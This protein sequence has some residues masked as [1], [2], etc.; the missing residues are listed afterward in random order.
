VQF[1]IDG[2]NVGGP[3]A[4]SGGT[5][6]FST[7]AL[8][9]GTHTLTALYSG[10]G[11][12]LASSGTLM[13]TV[14]SAQ[15]QDSAIIAQVNALVSAGV[16]NSGN[17]NSL[18]VKLDSATA[19]LNAGNTVAGV[20]QLNAFVN[21]A[22]AFEKT[23]LKAGNVN[24]AQAMASLIS[25]ANLAINA[26]Q[27]HGAKLVDG[28]AT[29]SDSADAQPVTDA[30]QLVSDV[31]GVYLDNAD[32]TPVSA[33]EQARFDDAIA[34]LD[35]TFGPY[36]VDLV[37]V[38]AGDA[39]DAV[40][41][42]E[43]AATSAAGSAAD[44]VLGCTVAG[45]ITLLTGWNWYTGADPGAVRAGQYDFETI[46]M[47]ELGHAVGL[48]HS[49]DAGSVMYTYLAP[50]QT[51][52]TVT[53]Q[54]LSVLDSGA[55]T[56]PEPLLAA[57]WRPSQ[58]PARSVPGTVDA[59]AMSLV[60][61][62]GA[63]RAPMFALVGGPG[64]AT[65]PARAFGLM[66]TIATTP[67]A[68][69]SAARGPAGVMFAVA[70]SSGSSDEDATANVGEVQSCL[71]NG[72]PGGTTPAEQ[73]APEARR[74]VPESGVDTIRLRV[75]QKDAVLERAQGGLPTRAVEM[76]FAGQRTGA[77]DPRTAQDAVSSGGE[78]AWTAAA[79]A[80]AAALALWLSA[81]VRDRRANACAFAVPRSAR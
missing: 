46:V 55:G 70:T 3:V 35:A 66:A 2:S 39:A 74:S 12:F 7:A 19:S 80:G 38:G 21:Q 73:S 58:T 30:G 11:S 14:Y 1:Q 9:V 57:P 43:I 64:D 78:D 45:H 36:G 29:G 8:P 17:G 65:A 5:A 79:W 63:V 37:D 44:G 50:G 60:V 81:E 27:G 71:P 15:Q 76:L 56:A 31:L 26:I 6:S 18:I 24:G 69:A 32:G 68:L 54:D 51:R 72:A 77:G 53:A 49:G 22:M 20:G 47:H 67:D 62:L 25:A 41:Q 4:L 40:V 28:T 52:R 23:F 10:D 75:V 33:D 13:Q 48:G 59:A 34:A 42:V 61:G 16:L